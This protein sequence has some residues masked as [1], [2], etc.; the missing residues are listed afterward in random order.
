MDQL[1]D[2]P[3]LRWSFEKHSKLQNLPVQVNHC[4]IYTSILF[5]SDGDPVDYTIRT[6]IS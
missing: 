1:W 5:T 4:V 2:V 6:T 3:N